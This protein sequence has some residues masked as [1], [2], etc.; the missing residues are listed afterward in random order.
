MR[1]L[2]LF[3]CFF[4]IGP[5][6]SFAQL[7]PGSSCSPNG[8]TATSGSGGNG[9]WLVCQGGTWK[10]VFSH[11]ASG[12]ITVLGNQTCTNGQILKFNGTAWVCAADAGITALPALT[13]ARIW[14]GNASNAATAVAVSGDATMSNAGALTI[15]NNAINSAKIA[16]GAV[17]LADLAANSVNA[18]KI[19]D[20]SITAAKTAFVGMLT[21]GKWCNVSSGKIACTNDAPS[22][23]GGG[24][25]GGRLF[26]S[27]GSW[28]VPAGVTKVKASL[29][30]GGGGGAKRGGN[31][32][33]AC[34][35]GGGAFVIK[36][37]NVTPGTS[38]TVTI[39]AGGAMAAANNQDGSNGG[40]TAFGGV[41][42]NG[43]TG[44]YNNITSCP[45]PGGAASGGDINRSGSGGTPNDIGVATQVWNTGVYGNGGRGQVMPVTSASNGVA[46]M[47]LIEW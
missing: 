2:V 7:A 1:Y 28:T 3:L 21:N 17:E 43:G 18:S 20:G 37:I 25:S 12:A 39:G 45:T 9:Y 47:V 30:G 46:G 26:T 24:L 38:M 42:A 35:G 32:S 14:V 5:A 22:T 40:N 16:N 23:G 27:S 36:W 34:S 31:P 13:T 44:G 4:F 8:T 29:I 41:T 6:S 15:A 10:A 33:S 19:V 11:N